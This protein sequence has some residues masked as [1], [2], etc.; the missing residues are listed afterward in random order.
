LFAGITAPLK[1]EKVQK[2]SPIAAQDLPL[3]DDPVWALTPLTKRTPA[4]AEL[5]VAVENEKVGPNDGSLP[6]AAGSKPLVIKLDALLAV[7]AF[8]MRLSEPFRV[9]L[10]V[11]VREPET[12]KLVAKVAAGVTAKLLV[13]QAKTLNPAWPSV[14][15]SNSSCPPN[16]TE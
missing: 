1:A 16:P 15:V 8:G 6:V 7:V 14:R 10:P 13:L 12:D 2:A 5:V 4:V 9:A 11:A 3:V